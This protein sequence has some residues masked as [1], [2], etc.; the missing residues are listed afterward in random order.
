MMLLVSGIVLVVSGIVGMIFQIQNI[1]E[2]SK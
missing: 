1:R 2:K